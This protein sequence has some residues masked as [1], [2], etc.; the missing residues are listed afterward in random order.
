MCLNMRNNLYIEYSQKKKCGEQT[1]GSTGCSTAVSP[2]PIDPP[3]PPP[4]TSPL[5]SILHGLSPASPSK[6]TIEF[7]GVSYAE[8]AFIKMEC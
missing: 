4:P 6:V 5:P 3:H 7:W 1:T 8:N 2:P